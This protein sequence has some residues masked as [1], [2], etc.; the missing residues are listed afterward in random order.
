[1]DEFSNSQGAAMQAAIEAPAE[2]GGGIV[3]LVTGVDPFARQRR[4]L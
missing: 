3:A 2:Q 1:M 4:Y